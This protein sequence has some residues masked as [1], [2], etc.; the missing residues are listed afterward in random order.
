MT[1]EAKAEDHDQS[2]EEILQSIK[3]I[4]AEEGDENDGESIG[5]ASVA[6]SGSDILELTEMVQDDGTVVEL[7]ADSA[8]LPQSKPEPKTQAAPKAPAEHTDSAVMP[9]AEK[10]EPPKP[11]AKAAP[12]SLPDLGSKAETLVSQET[13]AASAAALKNLSQKSRAPEPVL[14]PIDSAAFRSGHTVEDL[15]LE[16]LRPMLKDWLDENLSTLVERLVEK[17]IR[18]IASQQ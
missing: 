2:M 18:K 8:I 13:A 7:A 17:E 1:A 14:Q 12:I 16:A 3:R 6:D 10:K 11:A 4:I 5:G 9:M 15:V